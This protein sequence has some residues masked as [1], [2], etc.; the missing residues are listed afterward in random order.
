M[1]LIVRFLYILAVRNCIIAL[2]VPLKYDS[3]IILY[4]RL[5]NEVKISNVIKKEIIN[6]ANV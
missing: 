2:K 1:Y 5:F 6:E 4:P 3:M